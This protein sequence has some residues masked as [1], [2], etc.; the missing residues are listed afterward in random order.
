MNV[1]SWQRKHHRQKR[2]GEG[3]VFV[4]REVVKLVKRNKTDLTGTN[5]HT[6]SSRKRERVRERER[7]RE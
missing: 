7:E 6:K 3:Q 4:C 2:R 1:E 5:R